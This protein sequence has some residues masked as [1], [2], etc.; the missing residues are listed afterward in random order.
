[1]CVCVCVCV[2]TCTQIES[3]PSTSFLPLLTPPP[4]SLSSIQPSSSASHNLDIAAYS[5]QHVD[6]FAVLLD[7]WTEEAQFLRSKMKVRLTDSHVTH[8]LCP[9]PSHDSH[10]TH[11]MCPTPSNESVECRVPPYVRFVLLVQ[12]V[13]SYLEAYHHVYD[14]REKQRLAEV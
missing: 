8:E 9:T 12:V 3:P 7:L 5:H 1:M 4:P 6:R 2:S 10:M 14:A 13:N 11:E